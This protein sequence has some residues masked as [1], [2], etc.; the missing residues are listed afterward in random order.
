RDG[1]VFSRRY[2]VRKSRGTKYTKYQ[3]YWDDTYAQHNS[4]TGE[5]VHAEPVA[6][7]RA[8]HLR[9]HSK[10]NSVDQQREAK[11]ERGAKRGTVGSDVVSF[12]G[13]D[14]RRD[15]IYQSFRH[16]AR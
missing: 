3:A 6:Y 11:C 16:K 7:K 9:H 8:I 4:I 13:K 1:T 12:A 2:Q 5:L 10:T 15:D 14:M